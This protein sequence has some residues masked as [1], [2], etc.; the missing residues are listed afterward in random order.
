MLRRS[1]AAISAI[2]RPI[3]LR[4]TPLPARASMLSCQRHVWC[5]PDVRSVAGVARLQL[6]VARAVALRRTR[7]VWCVAPRSSNRAAR[8]VRPRCPR[9][10][11]GFRRMR[12]HHGVDSR[13]SVRRMRPVVSSG[14]HRNALCGPPIAG[15][16][17]WVCNVSLGP[18][19][20]ER[21][22]RCSRSTW[23]S[24]RSGSPGRRAGDVAGG[25]VCSLRLNG[26]R[27]DWT[28]GV[29]A[30]HRRANSLTKQQ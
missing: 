30:R 25:P 5:N 16:R 8:P 22:E 3:G 4:A 29:R 15:T 1:N 13:V 23:L 18:G 7:D 21:P 9:H 6:G 12:P 11:Y 2:A 10:R 24:A 20:S 17:I 26:P 27:S 28:G 14:L 19:C